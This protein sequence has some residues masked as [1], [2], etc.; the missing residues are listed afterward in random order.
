MK[1][2]RSIITFIKREG[3]LAFFI[4]LV[5]YF[6]IPFGISILT[7]LKL[8]DQDFNINP[9]IKK[10]LSNKDIFSKIYRDYYWKSN[11]SIS[12]SGS[13]LIFLKNYSK[14]LEKFIKDFN[15]KSFFDVPCGDF[16]FMNEFLKKKNIS[17][18]GGDIVQELLENNKKKYPN[19]KFI[20]FDLITDRTDEYFEAIHVKDCLFHFS[21]EDANKA[22]K[23]ISQFNTKYTLIT[24]HKS[25]VLKNIDIETGKFRY[26]DL[27][28]HPFELPKPILRLKSY[29]FKLG[30]FPKYTCVWK[31]RDLKSFFK[32]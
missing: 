27:E 3:F 1:N 29:I 14:N 5:D 25:L 20:K 15:I 6:L 22:L 23:N 12:G 31:T 16:I 17:Y 11:E 18:K 4:K 9:Y 7:F 24:S 13:D 10:S 19:Y 30:S 28:K 8:N 2:Y 26:L 32:V 21:L